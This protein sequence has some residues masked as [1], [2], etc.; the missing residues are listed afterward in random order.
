[1]GPQAPVLRGRTERPLPCRDAIDQK[2]DTQEMVIMSWDRIEQVQ[3]GRGTQTRGTEATVGTQ[4]GSSQR[5][6]HL[7]TYEIREHPGSGHRAG[8]CPG[9]RLAM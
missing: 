9:G 1:M 4:K 3:S 7:N 6:G 8:W 5:G 2:H